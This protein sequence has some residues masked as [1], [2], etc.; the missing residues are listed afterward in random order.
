[1]PNWCII[2]MGSL[3]CKFGH[4]QRTADQ[5]RSELIKTGGPN[6]QERKDKQGSGNGSE[7]AAPGLKVIEGGKERGG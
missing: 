2:C 6:G 1:M 4:D 7:Q 3:P 5:R